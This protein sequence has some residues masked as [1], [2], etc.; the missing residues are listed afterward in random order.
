[1]RAKGWLKHINYQGPSWSLQK[2]AKVMSHV[3]DEH[4]KLKVTDRRS[5][6]PSFSLLLSSLSL[7]LSP[8]SAGLHCK[9]LRLS[10]MPSQSAIPT[11]V[12]FWQMGPSP[13]VVLACIYFQS[14]LKSDCEGVSCFRVSCCML[15]CFG[16]ISTMSAAG[17]SRH[18]V[19]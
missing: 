5:L 13:D 12:L 19:I 11:Y 10:G 4:F 16:Q 7:S 18:I 2:Y 14:A 6:S 8:L 15:F 1:M 9:R 17:S 3:I